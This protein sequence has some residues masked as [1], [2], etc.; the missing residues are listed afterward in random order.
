MM[1]SRYHLAAVIIVATFIDSLFIPPVFGIQW[2]SEKF[3][4]VLSTYLIWFKLI[5]VS[6][7]TY[8]LI[9][10][11][12]AEQIPQRLTVKLVSLLLFFMAGLQIVAL[13]VTCI[14]Y[15]VVGS[16]APFYQQQGNIVVY[17][18]DVGAFGSAYHHF[19]YQCVGPSGFYHY[20]PIATIDW[21]RDMSFFAKNNQL[22]IHYYD[23][24]TKTQQVKHIPLHG[25]SCE[26][27]SPAA[28]LSASRAE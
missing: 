8:V 18:S 24:K 25:L 27:S 9:K 22:I 23:F 19:G 10:T 21:L 2:H 7:A 28:K 4:Y 14:W 1:L 15:V 3:I 26:A 17:T 5:V 13:T 16:Q 6:I 12:D 20:T 11:L